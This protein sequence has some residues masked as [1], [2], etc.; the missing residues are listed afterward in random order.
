[1]D[2]LVIYEFICILLEYFIIAIDAKKNIYS[3]TGNTKQKRDVLPR[4]KYKHSIEM[5]KNR[6]L[7]VNPVLY[8]IRKSALASVY[9]VYAT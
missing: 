9:V 8:T 6:P 4:L 1:M 2:G 3:I 7:A 5:I